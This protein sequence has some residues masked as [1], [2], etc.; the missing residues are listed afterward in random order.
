[1]LEAG[2]RML[3][4]VTR[5]TVRVPV[6]LKGIGWVREC[7]PKRCHKVGSILLSKIILHYVASQSPF[8]RTNTP[9]ILQTISVSMATSNLQ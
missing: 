2:C 1:M 5:L 6:Q 3:G 4:D 8:I 7:F 9:I